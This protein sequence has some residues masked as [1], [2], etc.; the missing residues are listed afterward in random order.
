MLKWTELISSIVV[1]R[2]QLLEPNAYV[3]HLSN[4]SAFDGDS[5][6]S[7]LAIDYKYKGDMKKR[8]AIINRILTTDIHL[9]QLN[10]ENRAGV[11]VPDATDITISKRKWETA[12]LL[13]RKHLRDFYRRQLAADLVSPG[14]WDLEC[15]EW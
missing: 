6:A 11:D 8:S 14:L 12:C 3:M 10:A 15:G 13:F 9:Q 2:R 7:Y 1:Y 5:S 4:N